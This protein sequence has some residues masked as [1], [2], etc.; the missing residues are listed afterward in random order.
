[1]STIKISD[2]TSIGTVTGNVILPLVS[3][4]AGTLTT[5]KG[6]V[7]QIGTY[8]L[9]TI[10]TSITTLLVN[11]ATQSDLIIAINANV[12]SANVGMK[13]YVDAVITSW[14]ANAGSQETTLNTLLANAATQS[15]L[16]IGINANVS[17]A[18][19]GMIGYV[20]NSTVTANV[21]MKG[22]VDNSTTTANVGM[23]G[24]VD[25]GNTIQAGAITAA[26]VGMKGYVDSQSFYSN[27]KVA[28]YLSTYNGNIASATVTGDLLVIGNVFVGNSYVPTANNSSG[29]RG[30]I[31]WDSGYVYICIDTNTWK[32]ANLAVW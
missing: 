19:I 22:Y 3:N 6:N 23:K 14:T 20:D 27:T 13:G 28:T 32:R 5:G 29:V 2:L 8:I 25:F 21:G 31:A 24:Y 10:P 4:V 16:I 15:D 30:Q 12:A 18:N 1:M 11:A 17:A 26:N 9:G 7:D